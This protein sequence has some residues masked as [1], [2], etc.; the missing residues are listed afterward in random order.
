M[1]HSKK[2]KMFIY[3]YPV[4]N[5]FRDRA[6]SLYSSESVEKEEMLCNVSDVGILLK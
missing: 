4:L 6:I 3:M 1:G 2:K 5:S